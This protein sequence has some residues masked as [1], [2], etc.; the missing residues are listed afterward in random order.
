M[1]EHLSIF[2]AYVCYLF[3][4]LCQHYEMVLEDTKVQLQQ[5]QV[6]CIVVTVSGCWCSEVHGVIDVTLC[7]V[8]VFKQKLKD[9]D[10]IIERL[11]VSANSHMLHISF[12]FYFGLPAFPCS[13][14]IWMYIQ[15]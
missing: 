15:G 5:M 3:V 14:I 11:Q 7:A 4:Q 8:T 13:F 1:R 2:S 10:A 12:Q 6:C 9:R